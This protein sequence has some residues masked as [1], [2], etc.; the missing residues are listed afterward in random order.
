M[1]RRKARTM[2]GHIKGTRSTL[3]LLASVAVVVAVLVSLLFAQPGLASYGIYQVGNLSGHFWDIL[4]D[5][6]FAYVAHSYNA[7]LWPF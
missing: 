6:N 7:G 1:M 3:R 2:F 4:V 5:G